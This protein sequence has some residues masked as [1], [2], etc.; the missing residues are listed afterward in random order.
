MTP[1]SPSATTVESRGVD[2]VP[3]GERN[4]R[5]WHVFTVLYGSNLTYS[6]IIFGSFPILFGLSWWASVASILC[7]CLIGSLLLA[8]MSLFGP[9]T[10]TNNA[11]SSGAHFGVA[12]RFI[13]TCLALF[14]ALGFIAI[15]IWTSG[16]A[17]AAGFGRMMGITPGPLHQAAC[18]ALIAIVVIVVAV[19]GF[20]L[21]VRIQER[22]MMPLMS[23]VLLLGLLAFGEGFDAG[24]AGGEYA[25]GDFWRTWISSMLI[26]ASVVLSY[27]VFVGDWTRYIDPQRHSCPSIMACTFF[28]G[29]LGMGGPMLWGAFVCI[30]F[31]GE[32]ANFIPAL[33]SHSPSWYVAGLVLLGLVAGI[34]QATVGL[35]GTGL[36]TSSLIPRLNRQ[37]ATL[38]I[39]MVAVALVYLGVFAWSAVSVVNAFLVLLLVITAPW[40]LIMTIGY[41]QRRGHYHCD[42]LQ[43]FTRAQTG[44]RYWYVRGINWRATGA[45]LAA[46]LLGLAFCAAPPL[47]TGPWA[48]LAGGLDLSFVVAFV[49]GGLLFYLSLLLYPEPAYV[50]GP[51]GPGLGTRE[52]AG[53]APREIRLH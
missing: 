14:S 47:Y 16:D 18:Y 51:S 26:N 30:S 28:G 25:L 29:V 9:R 45:W 39:A 50:F 46:A 48:H 21:L 8:P 11:V 44:G 3:V 49:C 2:T 6:V 34:A 38:G 42:D 43:V 40:I 10:G 37:Q 31:A 12:G 24:Y 23:A 36:D 15:T 33:I 27:G 4:Y 32:A 53:A 35:Y 5:P 20:H 52:A 17:L 22:L 41:A 19:R 13:G 1:G 7:G